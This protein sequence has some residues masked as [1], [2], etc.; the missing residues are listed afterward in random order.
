METLAELRA[1]SSSEYQ[2]AEV[3]A[4]W[5]FC[6]LKMSAVRTCFLRPDSVR[7]TIRFKLSTAQVIAIDEAQFFP[8]LLDFCTTAAD[9]DAKVLLVAGLDGDFQ[10]RQFGQ[11]TSLLSCSY[12]SRK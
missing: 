5:S 4:A 2:A 11:V 7:C 8:D 9:L 12:K 10:R 6:W 1:E 3:C